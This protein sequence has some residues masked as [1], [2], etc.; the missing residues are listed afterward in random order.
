M[1]AEGGHQTHTPPAPHTGC[2]AHSE[3]KPDTPMQRPKGTPT[4]AP[5]RP[6]Q[7]GP[8]G[9]GQPEDRE[10]SDGW[11]QN[12]TTPRHNTLTTATEPRSEPQTPHRFGVPR[13]T[14]TR[15]TAPK[16]RT[17]ATHLNTRR[18]T[19]T[20]GTTPRGRNHKRRRW[21]RRQ[22][23]Q[24]RQ[25]ITHTKHHYPREVQH[26]TPRWRPTSKY[27]PLPK[28]LTRPRNHCP[29]A[30]ASPRTTTPWT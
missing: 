2:R 9:K 10:H 14:T 29:V 1:E 26:P 15:S 5:R 17:T 19:T 21:P 16:T 27:P 12:R 8:T 28:P 20:T 7:P 13:A 6:A 11:T 24:T 3:K 4:A 30:S 25:R 18:N 22:R 23:S